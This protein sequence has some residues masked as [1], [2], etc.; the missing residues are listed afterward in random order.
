MEIADA[1]SPL[2]QKLVGDAKLP[3]AVLATPD[4]T[5]VAKVENKDGYLRVGPVE[6][7][8]DEELKQRESSLEQQL[9]QAKERTK[10]GDSAGAI[11][12]Y[13][14]VL[15]QKASSPEKQKMRPRN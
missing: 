10:S 11:P 13:R 12:L 2:G 9:K 1:D 7:L 3:I 6:K 4:G 8:V 5:S 14:A 15:D